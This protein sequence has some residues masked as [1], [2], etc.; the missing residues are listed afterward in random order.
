[1]HSLYAALPMPY[2]PMRVTCG[3]LLAYRYPYAPPRRR[4]LQFRKTFI[5]LSVSQWNDIADP[6]L[7]GVGLAGFKRKAIASLLT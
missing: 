6:V 7:D 4:T 1:M 5:P 2:V 3:A